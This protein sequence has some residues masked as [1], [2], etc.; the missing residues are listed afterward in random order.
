VRRIPAPVLLSDFSSSATSFFVYRL[1]VAT[2]IFCLP[3]A[4][5]PEFLLIKHSFCRFCRL[6]A[7]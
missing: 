3:L 7:R 1:I 4:E 6:I 5:I 2:F